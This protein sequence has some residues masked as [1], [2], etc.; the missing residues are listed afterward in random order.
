MRLFR[1]FHGRPVNRSAL[2]WRQAG[3]SW[4]RTEI[5]LLLNRLRSGRVFFAEE[6]VINHP[7]NS[8]EKEGAWQNQRHAALD[9]KTEAK[10]RQEHRQAE[11]DHLGPTA[12]AFLAFGRL[13]ALKR[14]R[15]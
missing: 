13:D 2:R 4:R 3:V 14:V 1:G 6:P 7:E 9:D 10:Y 8:G 15:L 11:E 12:N 5:G